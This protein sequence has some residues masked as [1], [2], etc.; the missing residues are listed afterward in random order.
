MSTPFAQILRTFFQT[1]KEGLDT[2]ISIRMP[3]YTSANELIS[4]PSLA[5]VGRRPRDLHGYPARAVR[6][7]DCKLPHRT[8]AQDTKWCTLWNRRATSVRDPGRYE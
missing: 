4:K 6:L 8:I 5:D 7:K 1:A 2:L 3:K